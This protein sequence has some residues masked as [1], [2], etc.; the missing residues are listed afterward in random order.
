[1]SLLQVHPTVLLSI[2]DHHQ[3]IASNQR[4]LGVLL[5]SKSG[6][7]I[8]AT[9]CFGIPFEED[10]NVW[11]LDHNYLENMFQLFKKVN[12]KERIIGWYHSGSKLKE[13]DLQ[14]HQ[15][16]KEYC[17]DPALFVLPCDDGSGKGADFLDA[18]FNGY[19]EKEEGEGKKFIPL[20]ITVE[21][22]EAEEIGVEHLVRD[23]KDP[24]QGNLSSTIRDKVVALA[25]L[26][27]HLGTIGKYL[28]RVANKDLPINHKIMYNL[29]NIFNLMPNSL[30]NEQI[31]KMLTL[32]SND[33]MMMNYVGSMMKGIVSLHSLIDNSLAFKQQQ[34]Q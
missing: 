21:S 32:Y 19:L 28:E 2:L 29:Q 26:E 17:K 5:G 7:I 12:A 18:T 27:G 25:E 22:E 20:P 34:Q 13:T 6:S 24:S 14:I 15:V 23:I 8:N 33:S 30:E 10:L 3:R 16:F 4:V 11:F 31:Q 1:M 9:N